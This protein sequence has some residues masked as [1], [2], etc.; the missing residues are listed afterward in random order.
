MNMA[1]KMYKIKCSKG[2][3]I[4]NG[5]CEIANFQKHACPAII[6]KWQ[7]VYPLESFT[8]EEA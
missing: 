1:P 7:K 3:Y 4:G 8:M 2:G 5:A 6:A